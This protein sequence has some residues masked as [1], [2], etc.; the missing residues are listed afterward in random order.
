MATKERPE[1]GPLP[2]K[3]AGLRPVEMA[4][5]FQLAAI[6]ERADHRLHASQYT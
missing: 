3:T 4:R 5:P 1:I 6:F 2:L